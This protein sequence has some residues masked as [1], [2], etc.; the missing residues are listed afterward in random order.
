MAPVRDEG[1]RPGIGFPLPTVHWL[2]SGEAGVHANSYF[3]SALSWAPH[4]H[5]RMQARSLRSIPFLTAL[6]LAGRAL[7]QGESC[8]TAVPVTP[9]IYV[10]DGPSAGGGGINACFVGGAV[11]GDWYSFTP[12][13]DGTFDV[14]S[15]MGGADTR[16]SILTGDCGFQTCY[17]SGD[18]DCQYAP[19]S[20]S[21]ASQA[22]GL[23]AVAGTT[24]YIQW[25]DNWST[26]GFTWYL[27]F[28]CAAAPQANYDIELAC[29]L[30]VYYVNVDITS[31]GSANDVN[32]TNNGGAPTV[33][34]VG[35]GSQTVGPFALNT[36]VQITLVNNGQTGCDGYSPQLVNSPCPLISCGPNTYDYCYGNSEIYEVV[37]QGNSSYPLILQFNNGGIYQFDGDLLQIYDASNSA[38]VPIYSGTGVAGDLT[39][40]SWTSTNPDHALTLKF[41]SSAFTG[42]ADGNALPWNYT[43]G[44]LDC[45]PPSGTAGPAVTDCDA[46]GFTVT[47]NVTDLGTDTELEIGNDVGVPG[48]MVTTPGTYTVGPFPLGNPATITL[49][50]DANSLC[51]VE[52]GTFVNTYCPIEITCGNPALIQ[53]YCYTNNDQTVWLYQNNGPESLA[54]LWNS[55]YLQGWFYDSLTI[56]DGVDANAPIL[57]ANYQQGIE[58]QFTDH[59]FGNGLLLISQ[60][61]AIYVE[62]VSN[63]FTSCGDNGFNFVPWEWTVGCLDCTQPDATF[64]MELNCE[65]S[66]FMINTHVTGVGSDPSLQLTNTLNTD[67]VQITDTGMYSS[68]PFAYGTEIQFTLNADVNT[69]CNMVSPSFTNDP[70]CAQVSCASTDYEDCYGNSWDTTIVYQSDTQYPIA[71]RWNAGNLESCCD[72]VDIRNGNHGGA[73]QIYYGN[74]GGQDMSTVDAAV[75]NNVDNALWVHFTSD[76]SINCS[77]GTWG[78][79]PLNWTVACLDCTNPAVSFEQVPDCIHNGFVVEVTVTELGTNVPSLIIRNTLNGDTITGVQTGTYTAGPFPVDSLVNVIVESA[80]N[81]LCRQV[82][83]EYTYA[84]SNCINTACDPTGQEYCYTNA[85]TAWFVYTSGTSEPITLNFGYGELLVND[86]I[87]IFN[88]LDTSAQIVYMGNQGGQLDGLSISSSNPDNALTL[89]VISSQQGSCATG[90]GFPPL[91]W[92]VGCGL[93]GE[94]EY[95]VDRFA[96]FPNPTNAD[97]YVR[98]AEGITGRVNM[99]VMDMMGRLVMS[100]QFNATVGRT[101]RFD[102]GSLTNGN[103]AV[104]L[105]TDSWSKTEQLQV[106]R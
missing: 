80:N 9:G 98:L 83:P 81:A 86:Y 72:R 104:R 56:Y 8:A 54:M 88:G 105:S 55:L 38:G 91:Y 47:V 51:N 15:C 82:S 12:V 66:T 36:P 96:M 77:D 40:L 34:N 52:L 94:N 42:C 27:N 99:D 43:V 44:C 73:Q 11:N 10:A 62:L 2:A 33:S 37:Y 92:T 63:A 78:Y 48:T 58:W 25:D 41:T 101:E 29:D 18:D 95:T 45:T 64:S 93:V 21:F 39:G 79:V 103:Y 74:N 32:I 89:L 65:D 75:S 3:S 50:N 68:G 22:L 5:P 16:L 35:L 31:L 49:V 23:V 71:L 24:Y 97:V 57:W 102:L 4:T 85:D 19:G 87:Q 70:P 69:L 17:G 61:P 76:G 20:S 100:E 6:L 30:G 28:F 90:Q 53:S 1:G 59:D 7:P 26:A 46:Q 106:V 13:V 60:G 84:A 14:G 67:V